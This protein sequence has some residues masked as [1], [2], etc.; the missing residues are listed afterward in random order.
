[1]EDCISRA[2]GYRTYAGEI[3]AIVGAMKDPEAKSKLLRVADDYVRMAETLEKP[4]I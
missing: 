2:Q 4:R 1:M 3:R